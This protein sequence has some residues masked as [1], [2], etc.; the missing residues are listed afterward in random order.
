MPVIIDY[1]VGNLDSVQRG[2]QRMGVETVVS[3]DPAVIAEANALIL[4]GVG[5]FKKAME[6]LQASGLIPHLMRHVEAGKPLL[7][8]CLGMQLL[9]EDSTEFGHTAG[10]GL[11][12]GSV[13]PLESGLKVPHMGWNALRL[14]QPD[15]PLLSYVNAGEYVY[16]V[17]SFYADSPTED[18][19]AYTDYGVA[20]PAVVGRKN[21]YGTQF[22]PEKSA[23]VGLRL[24]KGFGV[25]HDDYLSSH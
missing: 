16:F 20:I 5:A 8:I 21:V 25:I 13:K 15:H 17:H 4:P 11:L 19:L 14:I 7:G 2:F 23:D 3:G 10:L 6:S 9:Y 24:L 22:H 1:D 18:V 12:K